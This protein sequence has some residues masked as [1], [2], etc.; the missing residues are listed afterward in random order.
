[1][2]IRHHFI[3]EGQGDPVIMLHGNG[4]NSDYFQKQIGVFAKKYHVYALDSRGHGNTPRGQ[5]AFTIKQFAD[6]LLAFMDDHHIKKAHLLGF[7]DGGNVAMVFAICHPD[8]VDHLI[9]NGANMD[10]SGVKWSA[11]L[12]VEIGYRMAKIASMWSEN[13]RRKAGILG[14]MVNDPHVR[15]DELKTIRAKTLVIAGTKDVIKENHTRKIAA[16]I[17]GSRLVLI[18]GDHY[19]AFKKAKAFNRVVLNFLGKGK[20]IVHD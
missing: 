19:I 13:A 17:P 5:K 8:R 11:Q 14:L 16:C 15:P 18:K 12:P 9:L 4:E 1:M 20:E 7:S 2:D 10:P 6:D 3:E